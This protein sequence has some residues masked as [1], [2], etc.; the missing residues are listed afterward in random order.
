MTQQ[1]QNRHLQRLHLEDYN[2]YWHLQYRIQD[3]FLIINIYFLNPLFFPFSL[4]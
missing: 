2:T 3:Y 1:Q 4:S